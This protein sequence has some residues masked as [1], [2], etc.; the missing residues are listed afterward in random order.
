MSYNIGQLRKN[1]INS[2]LSGLT[3]RQGLID[4]INTI[5]VFKDPCLF[6]SGSNIV[7]PQYS[8][9]LKFKVKQ[10]P[11]YEQDFT[12]K[13]NNDDVLSQ[14]EQSIKNFSVAR[15]NSYT[16]FEF[17]F[18]PNSTYNSIIFELK[19]LDIDF[20]GRSR[21]MDVQI[22]N[23]SIVTNIIN[24]YLTPKY[25][26]LNNKL[27]K[28]GLQSEPGLLFALNGEEIRVGRSGFYELFHKEI[29]IS[30]LGFV[31]EDGSND[32]FILDFK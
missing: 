12:V 10:S 22:E 27:I 2:Y 23:F 32:F 4:S 19:R 28:I 26:G 6:L 20:T 21:V 8:Y 15:G 29:I 18:S 5:I 9:Y 17:V 30:Y 31:I 14:R 16:T 24:S 25:E 7:T 1:E 11:S 13:L 3:Y